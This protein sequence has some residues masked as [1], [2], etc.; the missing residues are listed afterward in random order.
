MS[1]KSNSPE[2]TTKAMGILAWATTILF[3][4]VAVS[5]IFVLTLWPFLNGRILHYIEHLHS[6]QFFSATIPLVGGH[7]IFSVLLW[8]V[9]YGLWNLRRGRGRTPRSIRAARGTAITETLIVMPIFLLLTCGMAQMAINNATVILSNLATYEAARAVWVWHPEM[10]RLNNT[11]YSWVSATIDENY[12]LEMG[13]IQAAAV[14]APVAHSFG[15]QVDDPNISEEFYQLRGAFVGAHDG[16]TSD[17]GAIGRERADNMGE[18][19]FQVFG[20]QGEHGYSLAMALD[21]SRYSV[22]S[23]WKFSGAYYSSD[24]RYDVSP[25]GFT[26]SVPE[27]RVT[28]SYN[29]FLAVPFVG[30][31]FGDFVEAT[32]AP[33]GR[34][35]YYTIYE[36]TFEYVQ[37]ISAHPGP[38]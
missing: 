9:G 26:S 3:H 27:I 8:A 11:N 20:N 4:V 2:G 6:P 23:A 1:E 21:S 16:Q 35:G 33:G 18:W 29:H 7:L 34:G 31:V 37:Q 36:N 32:N 30:W 17:M 10:Q 5:V 28:L 19:G 38:A 13:R 22:R 14:M 24:V 12:V 15:T 25:T